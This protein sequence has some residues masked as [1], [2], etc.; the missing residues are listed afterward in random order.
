VLDIETAELNVVAGAFSHTGK[1]IAM[2]TKEVKEMAHRETG[3]L[4]TKWVGHLGFVLAITL[5]LTG[6][7]GAT[8][9]VA[10]AEK[11][12]FIGTG[13]VYPNEVAF[14]VNLC[15][16]G[17]PPYRKAEWDFDGDGIVDT[18]LVGTH[19][20]VMADVTWVYQEAGV[21]TVSLTMTDYDWVE[22]TYEAVDYVI[23]LGCEDHFLYYIG[24]GDD[25]LVVEKSDALQAIAD[26]FGDVIPPGRTRPIYKH[27]VLEVIAMYFNELVN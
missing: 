4:L 10:A 18:T 11:P 6:L 15:S 19:D 17:T 24:L 21:Y 1:H 20:E 13:H 8:P 22:Y 16:V 3:R 2:K 25:P 7:P 5:L 26:Y 14:F 12:M 27:E 23:V 9:Q